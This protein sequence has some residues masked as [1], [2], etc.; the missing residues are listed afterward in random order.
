MIVRNWMTPD[1]QTIGSDM[2]LAEA[3]RIFSEQNV[4]AL[5]V[6]DDAGLRGLLT[7]A[8]CVRAAEN[9]ARTQDK[10]EFEY[11]TNRLKVKD[12]M[13][14]QPATVGAGDTMEQCLLLG[15]SD[16]QSQFPV[17]DNGKVIGIVTATEIFRMAAHIIGAW[18]NHSGVTLKPT[19]IEAGSLSR[20]TAIVDATGACLQSIYPVPREGEKEKR[21]VVRFDSNDLGRVVGAFEAAG[22]EI[23]EKCFQGRPAESLNGS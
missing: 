10:H 23:L 14:R 3:Y 8:H 5:P 19:T 16:G 15:Q 22:Y 4:R 1:P 20:I 18:D 6:V 17:L 13:V 9:V 21:I 12:V 11:F 7:R 2:P